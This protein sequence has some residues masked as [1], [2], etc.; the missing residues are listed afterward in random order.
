[1]KLNLGCGA[2]H[3]PG[4]VNVDSVGRYSPDVVHD[5]NDGQLPFDSESVDEIL[6][7]DVLEHVDVI[8]VLSECHRVLKSGA[9]CKIRVPHFTYHRAYE[10]PT[11]INFFSV[12]SFNFFVKGHKQLYFDFQFSDC[13]KTLSFLKVKGF[14]IYRP[15]EFIV[16]RSAS[17][18]LLYE[19]TFLRA[20][21][22]AENINIE[23][24]K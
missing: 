15:I 24:I 11:H 16:N 3:L 7:R 13:A 19:S 8:H 4:Y 23:L 20:L 22:P 9:I 17:T 10:D 21:F 14:A 12:N 18:L 5:L 6:L 1:M 2:D